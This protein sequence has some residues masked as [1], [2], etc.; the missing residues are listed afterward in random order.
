MSERFPRDAPLSQVLKAFRLLGFEVVR[1]GNHISMVREESD[2]TK[3]PLTLPSHQ[4]IKGATLRAVL[5]QSGIGRNEFL[6][7][8]A[9]T[10]HHPAPGG[11]GGASLEA[12]TV[13]CG[14]GWSSQ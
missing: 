1:E 14:A 12:P 7:A 4:T 9:R 3:T 10:Q 6:A 8:Y 5:R 2:G 13:A 11:R